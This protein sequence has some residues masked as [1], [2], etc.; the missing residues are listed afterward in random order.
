M[1]PNAWLAVDR[2]P[3]RT[4]ADGGLV[5]PA[6]ATLDGQRRQLAEVHGHDGREDAAREADDEAARGE[7][8]DVR[9]RGHERRADQ[10]D[11]VVERQDGAA[12]EPV[13]EPPA[14]EAAQHA[15]HGEHGHDHLPDRILRAY[16]ALHRPTT[17]DQTAVS[18]GARCRLTPG[19]AAYR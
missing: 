4:D 7:D 10:H 9:R 5:Q 15:A 14:K 18:R 2:G 17:G 6:D 19:A 3:P 13:C 12:A 16:P 1:S 8:T 11:D